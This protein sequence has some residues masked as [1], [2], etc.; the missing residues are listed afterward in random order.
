MNL[1][2]QPGKSVI[3]RNSIFNFLGQ[4]LPMLVGVVTIPYI[5]KGLGANGYGILSIAYVVLGYF[6]IFDLGL[7]RAT[8]KFVADHL[9]PDKVHKVPGLIWTSLSLLLVLGCIGGLLIMAFVPI[10]VTRFLKMPA[11]F[12]G[13]ARISLYI[14]A[15]SMPVML[16]SDA[17]RGVLEAAQRFDLINYVKVPGS[18]CFYLF[19]ALAIP[20]GLR[21]TGIVAILV[22]VRLA[23]ATA[24][25]ALS[26]LVFPE[27]KA[28]FHFSRDAIRP[29]TVFGGWIMVTNITAPI[30][31]YLER[32]LIASVISVG[33]LTYYSVP[34]D[35]IG[36]VLIFP[37]SI[38]PS[39][40]PYF[41]YH[42]SRNGNQVT[43]VTSRVIKYLLLVM[44]P[45]T[46]VFVFFAREILQLWLGPQFASQS[47][48]VLKIVAV[49]FFFNAFSL[50][51]FTSVQALGR[52]DLKAIWDI[53]ALPIYGIG[54]WW[55]MRR[56][57][58]NGAA[59]AKLMISL[60]DC[61]LLYAMAR[62]LKAFSLRDLTSGPLLRAITVSV[63][64][65]S[66]VFLIAYLHQSLLVSLALLLIC[67]AFYAAI[68]W[69]A[70]VDKEE[71]DALCRLAGQAVSA[72]RKSKGSNTIPVA[73]DQVGISE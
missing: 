73:V 71:R 34:F 59:L 45:I 28:G 67:F 13:E 50:I 40:F 43:D 9:S 66:V 52:P 69:L 41:S 5:V 46:A 18:V 56:M 10:L 24:Y 57:G 29:L 22:L 11:S 25:L 30:F 37:T 63:A 20:L 36:K 68:F 53:I 26:F 70:A 55:L 61:A 58:I 33:M 64:L 6:S 65:F 47:A 2:D 54:A 31:G 19:A 35:L 23:T 14:L 44:T 72:I 12:V 62:R 60:A 15:A 27:L 17:L 38:V 21:V 32:F 1:H 7:S 48:I 39:L 8:V 49:L 4:I 3:A 16:G 42:G 51:P